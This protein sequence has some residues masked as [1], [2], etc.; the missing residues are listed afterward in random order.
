MEAEKSHEQLS[1]SWLTQENQWCPSR[2][3]EQENNIVYSSSSLNPWETEVLRAGEDQ[4][5]SWSRQG[6]RNSPWPALKYMCS[7]AFPWLI[8]SISVDSSA[9][10]HCFPCLLPRIQI[11]VISCLL[12]ITA[13]VS[14]VQHVQTVAVIFLCYHFNKVTASYPVLPPHLG[15]LL[16]VS[17]SC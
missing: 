1:V 2:L 14:Q 7:I 13:C 3:R 6:D 12:N 8:S 16:P 4:Y 15:F 10:G 5:S 11:C 17:P 9:Q